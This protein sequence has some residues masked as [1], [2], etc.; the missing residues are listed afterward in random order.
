VYH[1]RKPR[2]RP[3]GSVARTTLPPYPQK[4]A[5]TSPTS[6]DRSVGMLH[7]RTKAT[8]FFYVIQCNRVPGLFLQP[9]GDSSVT[10]NK[11]VSELYAIYI[12]SKTCIRRNRTGTKIFSTLDK[13]P[14]YKKLQKKVKPI[15]I[16]LPTWCIPVYKSKSEAL[17][18]ISRWYL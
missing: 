8:S 18:L 9:R 2:I 6:D 12:H 14:H 16:I 5:L 13:F 10:R 7:S 15:K 3:W 17:A 1:S 4:L 11:L